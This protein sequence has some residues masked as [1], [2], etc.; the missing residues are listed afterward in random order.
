[1]PNP[2][3][4]LPLPPRPS[5]ERYRKLAKELLKASKSSDETAISEWTN[6]WIEAIAK[7]THGKR[8]AIEKTRDANR[9]ERFAREQLSESCTLSSAQFVI[10]RSHGFENWPKFVK[11]LNALAKQ[12]SSLS[13]FEA[14]ADAIITG[15]FAALRRL[16]REDPQL[17]HMRSTREHQ[18][19]LLHYVAA[20]GVENYRQKTPKNIVQITNL[21]LEAGA[22]IDA[23]ANVYGGGATTLGLAATSIHPELAGVQ[24]GLL[25]T[26]LDHG[27]SIEQLDSPRNR[28]QAVLSCLANGR[29]RAAAFLAERGAVLTLESAAGIGRLDLVRNY[30]EDGGVLKP[31]ATQKQLESG[32]LYACG[33]GH[34]EVVQFLLTKCI[35]LAT[36]GGDGQTGLHCAV[37]GGHL[38]TIKLLLQH[39]PP[40]DFENIYGGTVLGQTLW[41]AAH[42][43]DPERYTAIIRTL[44]AAGARVPPRHAAINKQVDDLLK[45]HGSHTEPTWY[46]SE[47]EKPRF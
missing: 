13:R 1:M 42:G 3:D 19:T 37:I 34:T 23:T 39:N 30:F 44:I 20:N 29:L 47:D 32:F 22:E 4:V 35:D 26:L 14:A 33:Y 12:S 18:A 7:H 2:Q 9:T 5:L 6:R 8:P 16:L 40:L 41:S 43:G 17:I 15:K 21:L 45:K 24:V 25:Q 36:H 38:D 28:P 46:W 31:S 27:A 10:A 11:H